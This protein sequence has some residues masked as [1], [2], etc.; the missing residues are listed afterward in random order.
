MDSVHEKVAGCPGYELAFLGMTERLY[1]DD[2]YLRNFTARV[3]RTF[4]E[5]DRSI[6][7][8]DRTCFYPEGGGQSADRGVLSGVRVVDVLQEAGEVFHIV[9]S[10]E[11]DEGQQIEGSIDFERRFD[12]MQQHSGQHLLSQAFLQLLDAP[13]EGF[14]LGAVTSTLDLGLHKLEADEIYDVEELANRIVFEN[15]RILVRMIDSDQQENLSLRKTS[16]REGTIRVVEIEGFDRSPCGGT[17]CERT[18]GVGLIKVRRWERVNQKVRVE[19]Y[20]GKRALKDYRWKNRAVYMLSR[21]YSSSDRDVVTVAEQKEKK[22][23]ELQKELNRVK[24]ASLQQ[25]ADQLVLS[26]STGEGLIIVSQVW[27]DMELKS[28]QK[29]AAMIV[30]GGSRRVVLF[31]VRNPKPTLLFMRSSDLANMDAAEWIDQVAPMIAGRGG[32]RPDR[33]QAGGTLGGCLEEALA[34]AVELVT[35]K[36]HDAETNGS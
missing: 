19:F 7:V 26:S 9:E 32:G 18:G 6:V 4:T 33:A 12:H 13:T 8:L 22:V 30:Q 25:T 36:G 15:R 20:C 21:L 28:I 23:R 35:D 24:E 34:R 17:H 29:L 27:D 3:E 2:S 14:H 5:G 31:G 16:D 11:L 1:Y 10:Q